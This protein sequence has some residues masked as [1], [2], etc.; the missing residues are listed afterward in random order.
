MKE[1][2]ADNE[3]KRKLRRVTS[4]DRKRTSSERR[5]YKKKRKKVGG[6][7]WRVGEAIEMTR[8]CWGE[9]MNPRRLD[10]SIRRPFFFLFFFLN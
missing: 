5:E 4:K 9:G 10:V 1:T 7:E 8:L 3:C 2:S 6:G